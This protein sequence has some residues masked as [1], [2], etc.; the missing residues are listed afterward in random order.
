MCSPTQALANFIGEDPATETIN[1][2]KQQKRG[3]KR[4]R[5]EPETTNK[6][7][8]IR[9]DGTFA[10]INSNIDEQQTI[11]IWSQNINGKHKLNFPT[12]YQECRVKEINVICLQETKL[13]HR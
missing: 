1:K 11:K 6:K 5:D 7:S 3:V 4:K 12:I 2:S 8:K 10:I 13:G 9:Q